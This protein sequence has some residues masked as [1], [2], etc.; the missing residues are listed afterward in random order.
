MS[1]PTQ[2]SSFVINLLQTG[3]VS[4]RPVIRIQ[5][6]PGEFQR[7]HIID[8]GSEFTVQGD[9]LKVIHGHFSPGGDSATLIVAEFRFLSSE[10]SRQ[11]REATIEFLFA[12]SFD[13]ESDGS[14]DPEVVRIAPIGK[15][16]MNPT[17][18]KWTTKRTTNA[19]GEAGGGDYGKLG[20]NISWE[21]SKSFEKE[22]Q[23]SVNGIVRIEG[24]NYGAKN[25]ARWDL[26]E[27]ASRGDGIPSLLRSVILLKRKGDEHFAA[28][29]KIKAKVDALHSLQ[30]RWQ[31]LLG[32]TPKDD[33]VFF[34]PDLGPLGDIPT[35]MDIENLSSYDLA[36]LSAAESM[37]SI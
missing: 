16:S 20:G 10:N 5:N 21:I 15:N 11:F 9:L 28:T 26:L 22:Y 24:R 12:D 7:R 17:Q 32:K 31:D 23:A 35:D 14:R 1:E 3:D 19:S 6:I 8:R 18:E 29:I 4:P 33:P 37:A 13:F 30:S 27:N 25:Q 34:N 36:K 2:P